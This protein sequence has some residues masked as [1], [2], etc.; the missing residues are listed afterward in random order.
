MTQ[1]PGDGG[2]VEALRARNMLVR[3]VRTLLKGAG[4]DI[5]E[6]TNHLVISCPGHP[7][8]GRIYVGYTSGDV[9]LRRCTWDYLG[10]LDGYGDTDPEAE[11]PLTA[12]KIIATLTGP[13][14]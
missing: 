8:Q 14:P 7:D 2:A 4:L 12:E 3:T 5:R 9:S 13:N 11:P 10:H 6:L 1:A